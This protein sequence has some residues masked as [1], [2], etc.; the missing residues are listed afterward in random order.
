MSWYDRDQ[1]G[2]LRL[3]REYM[4]MKETA[5]DFVLKRKLDHKLFWEGIVTTEKSVYQLEIRYTECF[6]SDPP[7]VYVKS[8]ELPRNTPHLW[9]NQKLSLFDPWYAKKAGYYN[10]GTTT[11]ATM[12][13]HAINWLLAFEVWRAIGIWPDVH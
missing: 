10:P 12:R 6:P 2:K 8:P 3:V 1:Q 4:A 9:D 13:V 7:D 11:A 5:P